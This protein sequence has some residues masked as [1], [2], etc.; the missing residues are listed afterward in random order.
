MFDYI[1]SIRPSTI[2][3]Y[4]CSYCYRHDYINVFKSSEFNVDSMIWH[5]QR[6]EN[7]LFNFCGFGETTLHPQF[8][9]MTSKLSHVTKI[10]WIT[11]GTKMDVFFKHINLY[12]IKNIHDIT[13]SIHVDQIKNMTEYAQYIRTMHRL[14]L[15]EKIKH[16]F[17]IIV[18]K[19]NVSLVKQFIKYFN[20]VV[21]INPYPF[22]KNNT[23][24]VPELSNIQEHYW[25]PNVSSLPVF[26][27]SCENGYRIFEVF[28]DGNIYD[29]WYDTKQLIGNINITTEIQKKQRICSSTCSMCPPMLKNEYN[30]LTIN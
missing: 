26:G 23:L 6:H 9:E 7:S 24:I 3:N 22:T 13:I 27:K 10:N 20:E 4:T 30:L 14:L 1:F 12:N 28:H 5:A 8:T 17:T 18:S 11:N 15:N 19:E 16:T 29:C 2:C 25:Q 21:L